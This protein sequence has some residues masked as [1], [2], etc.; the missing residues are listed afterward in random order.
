MLPP[1]L[2]LLTP[3]SLL[4][5]VASGCTAKSTSAPDAARGPS[6]TERQVFTDGLERKVSLP[7]HPQRIISLAP[8]VTEVLYLLGADDRLVGVTTHCNWPEAARSK[9]KIGD[10]IN[11]G[12]ERILAAKPDL[13]IAS[14]AGNDR[15]AVM[16]LVDLGL[17]V[18][19]TAPRSVE[20]I[21]KTV[22]AIG[23]ITDRAQMGETL[24]ARMTQRLDEVK[25]RLAGL[26]PVH[27]FFI[28]WFD[29][30]LTPGRYTFENGVLLLAGVESISA[31]VDQFYPRF[32]LEQVLARD[33]DAIIT[34]QHEG[35][36][37]PDLSRVAGWQRLRAVRA[38]RIYVLN[39]VFQHPSPRF[40]D[41]VE[42]L[43]HKLHPERFK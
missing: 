27:A 24:I 28:T 25:H 40:V 3:L 37:L 12:Y 34:V 15:S 7:R 17:P 31:D 19:V 41:G 1:A 16:K 29:P 30:L 39:E 43:A 21:F 18:Y 10:L 6:V 42:E 8:S 35:T 32:S 38:G 5:I 23:Q 33:P 2:R 20:R 22:E 13:V 36:L 11:P 14:T 9:P 4:A 26:P